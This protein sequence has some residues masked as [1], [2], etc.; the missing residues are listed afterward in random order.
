M[1]ASAAREKLVRMDSR[2]NAESAATGHEQIANAF[3]RHL[4]LPVSKVGD[5]DSECAT[6]GFKKIEGDDTC[7]GE[8]QNVIDVDLEE[9]KLAGEIHNVGRCAL[10]ATCPWSETELPRTAGSLQNSPLKIL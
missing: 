9:Q 1:I 6:N 5:D 8:P 3:D 10:S 4:R 7:N 2:K